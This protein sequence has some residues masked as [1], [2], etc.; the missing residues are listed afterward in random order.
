LELIVLVGHNENAKV[1]R[2]FWDVPLFQLL[3]CP[4]DFDCFAFLS[5][6]NSLNAPYSRVLFSSFH[7]SYRLLKP[8]KHLHQFVF[9]LLGL[10]LFGLQLLSDSLNVDQP[11]FTRRKGLHRR[12]IIDRV[13][14]I[15]IAYFKLRKSIKSI[16][17]PIFTPQKTMILTIVQVLAQ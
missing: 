7:D 14:E 1:A 3:P 8:I 9:G 13:F 5:L 10:L 15:Y 2:V 17:R 11:P 16:E 6:D 12:Q 4:E